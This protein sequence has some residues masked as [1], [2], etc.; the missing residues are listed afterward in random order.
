MTQLEVGP[1]Y[2]SVVPRPDRSAPE[3]RD[4]GERPFRAPPFAQGVTQGRRSLPSEKENMVDVLWLFG[5]ADDEDAV[6]CRIRVSR[7]ANSR[8]IDRLRATPAESCTAANAG[9]RAEPAVAPAQET[10]HEA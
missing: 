8:D 4:G 1:R 6:A 9:E 7:A 5:V 10:R 2:H 3:A